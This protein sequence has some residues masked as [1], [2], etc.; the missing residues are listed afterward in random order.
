MDEVYECPLDDCDLPAV[1]VGRYTMTSFA[2]GSVQHVRVECFAG[3]GR[4]MPATSLRPI[5]DE[6]A[7]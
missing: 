7:A 3:H 4:N 5:P 1:V 2:T 6:E